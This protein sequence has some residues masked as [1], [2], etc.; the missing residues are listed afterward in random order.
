MAI[1]QVVFLLNV[2]TTLSY[3]T[4]KYKQNQSVLQNSRPDV[5]YGYKPSIRNHFSKT[6]D[7]RIVILCSILYVSVSFQGRIMFADLLAV[8]GMKNLIMWSCSFR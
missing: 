1:S 6:R 3:E 2:S 8:E 4:E 7:H 5:T